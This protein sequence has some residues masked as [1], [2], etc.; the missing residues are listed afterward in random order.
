MHEDKTVVD[1]TPKR[2][3]LT[4][5]VASLLGGI[6][7]LAL[8][9]WAARISGSSALRSDALEGSVNVLAAAFGLGSL[10]FAEKPADEGHPYGHGKIEYFAQA[11]EGGLISL[12]GFLILSDT[13]I[14]IVHPAPLLSL[15]EGL[16]LNLLA[17]VMNGVLG[18]LIYLTGKKQNSKILVADGIHLFTDLLTT[19]VL[20]IGLVLVLLT[21]WSWLDP[22]LALGVA[23][24]LFRTGFHLVQDS[25][26]ALLDAENPALTDTIVRHLNEIPRRS[27]ITT[28]EMKAQSFGRDIH[29]DLHVV[30]P[31]FLS[32][33]EAHDESDRFAGDLMKKLGNGSVVHTHIDPCEREYCAECS[34]LDCPIRTRPFSGLKPFDRDTV[35]RPGNH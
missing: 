33:K 30:V 13:L 3:R 1:S 26:N 6:L 2:L 34:I 8:K 16:K 18:V 21:G 9:A 4:A 31:E 28:H 11:F 32:I 19:G 20:G 15:G 5:M 12:A 29:V 25:A 17:G 14:R 7:I 22:V 35:I 23:F 24:F 27:V 10:L